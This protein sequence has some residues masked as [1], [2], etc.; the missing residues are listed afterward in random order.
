MD[1]NR[2]TVYF[3]LTIVQGPFDGSS[4]VAGSWK[5][6]CRPTTTGCN[7]DKAFG[8]SEIRFEGK[9]LVPERKMAH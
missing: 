2:T 3:L 4:Q 8:K 6:P 5:V 1:M 7:I 9:E